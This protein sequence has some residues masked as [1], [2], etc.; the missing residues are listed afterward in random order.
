MKN[1]YVLKK[2]TGYKS[3][4]DCNKFKFVNVMAY[5]LL[6]DGREQNC[7]SSEQPMLRNQSL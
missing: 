5:C 3:K 7:S 6:C 1:T 2:I 4:G